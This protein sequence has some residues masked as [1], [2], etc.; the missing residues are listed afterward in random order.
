VDRRADLLLLGVY[1]VLLALL[2]F[3]RAGWPSVFW[4]TTTR[5]SARRSCSTSR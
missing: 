2:V 5:T 1:A 4:S 3:L